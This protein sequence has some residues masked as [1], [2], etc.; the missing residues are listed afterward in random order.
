MVRSYQRKNA[1]SAAETQPTRT[2]IAVAGW[3]REAPSADREAGLSDRRRAMIRPHSPTATTRSSRRR[4]SG[5]HGGVPRGKS[6]PSLLRLD[7]SSSAKLPPYASQHQHHPW[8]KRANSSP[9]WQGDAGGGRCALAPPC[10]RDGAR[11]AGLFAGSACSVCSVVGSMAGFFSGVA[12]GMAAGATAED[13][14][15]VRAGCLTPRTLRV[16][17]TPRTPRGVRAP[18]S[19]RSLR[20]VQTPRTPR[21]VRAPRGSAWGGRRHPLCKG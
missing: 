9:S 5:A 7:N 6:H 17:Q 21:G 11:T 2:A 8:T 10:G 20:E 18:R 1:G 15:T 16:V 12:L 4:S 14:S 13:S 3:T 19:R